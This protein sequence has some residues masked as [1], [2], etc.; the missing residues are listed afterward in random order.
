[1]AKKPEVIEKYEE[2]YQTTID[3]LISFGSDREAFEK[4]IEQI[5]LDLD[6]RKKQAVLCSCI[7]V[8]L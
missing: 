3:E 8:L 7:S 6:G 2:T 5:I 1:M 4:K